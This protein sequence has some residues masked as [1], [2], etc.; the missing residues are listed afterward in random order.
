MD[1]VHKI[2]LIRQYQAEKIGWDILNLNF[3]TQV[4]LA[5][6]FEFEQNVNHGGFHVKLV[7]SITVMSGTLDFS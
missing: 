6:A 5:G 7:C 2:E 3:Y 1:W 4:R